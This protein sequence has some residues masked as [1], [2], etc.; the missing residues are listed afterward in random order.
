[1]SLPPLTLQTRVNAL[2]AKHDKIEF[3]LP[4][5]TFEDL[6]ETTDLDEVAHL[7]GAPTRDVRSRDTWEAAAMYSVFFN[8]PTGGRQG[9]R[10]EL[11]VRQHPIEELDYDQRF[12]SVPLCS[13]ALILQARGT[14]SGRTV[15]A[16]YQANVNPTRFVR[17]QDWNTL[18]LN[19][20]P[21]GQPPLFRNTSIPSDEFSLDGSDNWLPDNPAAVWQA[22][23]G[24]WQDRLTDYFN[25]LE[26]AMREEMARRGRF[27]SLN[28]T[29]MLSFEASDEPWSIQ[30]VETYWEFSQEMSPEFVESMERAMRSYSALPYVREEFVGVQARQARS[31]RQ[32]FSVNAVKQ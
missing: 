2:H 11:L 13:G 27:S 10:R 25:N 1:M 12:Q 28:M 7:L 19:H 24:R 6:S 26:V 22:F 21:S 18:R 4:L 29:G 17:Y 16:E 8:R 9:S 20:R 3:I 31:G 15:T 32:R 5:G 14:G 23:I 30:R